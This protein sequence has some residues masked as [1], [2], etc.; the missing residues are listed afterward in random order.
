MVRAATP[1]QDDL[2]NFSPPQTSAMTNILNNKRHSKKNEKK[3]TAF[4]WF[5]KGFLPRYDPKRKDNT[6]SEFSNFLSYKELTY[7][8]LEDHEIFGQWANY[9]AKEQHLY[10]DPNKDLISC[11]TAIGYFSATTTHFKD[12]FILEPELPCFNERVMNSYYDEITREKIKQAKIAGKPLVDTKD[13]ATDEEV[14]AL[15]TLCLWEGTLK[16]VNFFCLN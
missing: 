12:E 3:K 5:D 10:G 1:D 13:M 16:G 6:P 15:G 11:G 2:E 8:I 7:K 4:K 14:R 9:L